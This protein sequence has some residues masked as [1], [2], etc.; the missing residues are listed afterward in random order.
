MDKIE[1][2]LRGLAGNV[3]SI[4]K[5]ARLR[6]LLPVIEEM[7]ALGIR[8]AAI[9]KTLNENGFVITETG[10]RNTLCRIRKGQQ[11]EQTTSKQSVKSAAPVSTKQVAAEQKTTREKEVKPAVA[12]SQKSEPK[13]S[14]VSGA[15][16]FGQADKIPA[17]PAANLEID[18]GE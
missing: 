2:A 15:A 8:Q 12:E 10:F 1:A 11:T 16:M 14:G 4:N 9:V 13:R 3:E 6:S 5:T 7:Q 17:L 18:E